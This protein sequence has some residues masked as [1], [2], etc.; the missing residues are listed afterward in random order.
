MIEGWYEVGIIYIWK[1]GKG[2]I[3]VGICK[4]A[5]LKLNLNEEF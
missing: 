2:A 1:F 5:L 4:G 3:V